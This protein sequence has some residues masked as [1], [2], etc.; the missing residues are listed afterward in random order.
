MALGQAATETVADRDRIF[1]ASRPL[2][3]NACASHRAGG[4]GTPWPSFPE[5]QPKEKIPDW[6]RIGG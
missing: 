5:A 1:R 6:R 2:M 4:D 3:L